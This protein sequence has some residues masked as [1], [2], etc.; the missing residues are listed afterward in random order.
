MKKVLILFD[1]KRIKSNTPFEDLKYQYCYEYLYDLARE[2]NMELFRAS[3][4][5]YSFS[6]KIFK[7][8]WTYKADR[9][10]KVKDIKPN[11]IYD[12][13]RL[14]PD[15]Q[16]FKEKIANDYIIINDPTFNLLAGNKL[17]TSLLFP[18]YHKKYYKVSDREELIR[19]LKQIK[20]KLIVLKPAVGS[21]GKGVII[22]E[23][24][25]AC[26][27]EIKDGLLASEFIDSS[28]GIKGITLKKHDLRLVF[29]DDKLIYSYIRTPAEGSLLAN[30]S[31]GGTMQIVKEKDIPPQ[32]Y[33]IVKEVQHTFSFF[34]HKIYAI[35]FIF[36][37]ERR[38]WIVEL[39]PMPGIY[40]TS[41][42]KKW[43][44]K[45]YLGIIKLFKEVLLNK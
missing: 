21:G 13:T 4:E 24:S 41:D 29:I 36:D 33:S 22:T 17:I 15:T 14:K 42:Q 9:W 2:N 28:L 44:K 39:N 25:K 27:L 23:K 30:I 20:G 45:M 5:W 31:M 12:K 40:F 43:Q 7:H 35:D 19:A 11:L 10:Q 18:K 6:Q 16:F 34:S 32:I 37:G 3:Y 26:S 1:K 8:A 38:P